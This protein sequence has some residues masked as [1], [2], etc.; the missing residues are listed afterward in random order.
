MTSYLYGVWQG[1]LCLTYI[2]YEQTDLVLGT[3]IGNYP[4]VVMAQW[5]ET[6]Y[7]FADMTY[8]I[9]Y[10]NSAVS[11]INTYGA[12]YAATYYRDTLCNVR[13]LEWV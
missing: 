3:H 13:S 11:Y 5:N 12:T 2:G 4:H 7:I 10:C 1:G 8:D 9:S 6:D